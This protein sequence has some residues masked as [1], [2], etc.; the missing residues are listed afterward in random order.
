MGE[1][2]RARDSRLDRDVAVKVLPESL[3]ADGDALARF[4]REAKAIAAPPIR[5]SSR[6]TTS[7]EGRIAYAV[8]E[9]LEGKRC[10]RGSMRAR[11]RASRS[12]TRSRSCTGS[13]RH[14][15]GIVHRDLK[16]QNLFLTR[17][18]PVKILDF[19]S[20]DVL[21][22]AA[23]AQRRGRDEARAAAP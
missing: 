14:D 23:I 21:A 15:R 10:A 4:E 7:R 2:L 22:V 20:R 8:M 12:I 11:S 3:L 18:G 9:L 1:G 17:D 6:S 16:P 5:T 19:G 13:R